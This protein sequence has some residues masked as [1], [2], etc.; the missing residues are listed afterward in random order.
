MIDSDVVW[1]PLVVSDRDI[2]DTLL[3]A[4]HSVAANGQQ[5]TETVCEKAGSSYCTTCAVRSRYTANTHSHTGT[6]T[7]RHG[8]QLLGST[9]SIKGVPITG[10]N[11][12]RTSRQYTPARVVVSITFPTDPTPAVS[13][14]IAFAGSINTKSFGHLPDTVDHN[15]EEI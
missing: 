1:M 9:V 5:T 6:M 3:L 13:L 8:L 10:M 15:T 7:H 2:D 11:S 12:N 14:Q 4:A